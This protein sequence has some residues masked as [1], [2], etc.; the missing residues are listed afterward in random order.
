[1]RH[2]TPGAYMYFAQFDG[3]DSRRG[4]KLL[5][6]AARRHGAQCWLWLAA[7]FAIN[8]LCAPAVAAG[9]TNTAPPVTPEQAQE[10]REFLGQL[11][12]QAGVGGRLLMGMSI[13]A[14]GI[15]VR[16]SGMSL[17]QALL[18]TKR[19]LEN[20]NV[21]IDKIFAP[22]TPTGDALFDRYAAA[23]DKRMAG[24]SMFDLS[25]HNPVAAIPDAELSTWE[26][27]FGGDPRYWELRY[28]CAKGSEQAQL[29]GGFTTPSQLLTEAV[30]RGIATSNT[31]LL[32]ACCSDTGSWNL[33]PDM[34]QSSEQ[35]GAPASDPD[36]AQ[37]QL[38]EQAQLAV[39]NAAVKLDPRQAWGY[40]ERAMYWFGLGDQARG[41]ADLQ[42]GNAAP[43]EADPCP[44][45][46]AEIANA[47]AETS[48]PWSAAVC[49][50]IWDIGWLHLNS[51]P[52]VL[53][54]RD[55]IRESLVCANLS[56]D[57]SSFETWH[58]Y[59]C[60]IA[61]SADNNVQDSVVKIGTAKY[62]EAALL[63]YIEDSAGIALTDAQ[64]ET[65]EHVRGACF[66]I[67]L[68]P[69]FPSASLWA[70]GIL[71][72]LDPPQ[73][74]YTA[75]YLGLCEEQHYANAAPAVFA[76][77]SQVHYPELA[78][79]E[80]MK[81]YEALSAEEQQRRAEERRKQYEEQS[82]R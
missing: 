66:G 70:T 67:S 59:A 36:I 22:P 9:D 7:F 55:H 25:I 1:M 48:P 2:L 42:E 82:K 68:Q 78:L 58:Q 33:P 30:Q 53:R 76:D 29:S 12:S 31:L 4:R 54:S 69:V 77:L 51:S 81:K 10:A 72:V 35:I 18:D 74:Y 47:P 19:T 17:E 15:S 3:T 45:P 62:I 49:G 64:R 27:E 44:W 13:V 23:V 63:D 73:G 50:A 41:L 26:P 71:A 52:F 79:P 75:R 38:E 16:N 43:V 34:L 20:S 5:T 60:H 24:S 46:L 28:F 56:G 80:C 37:M 11:A 32:L 6:L 61:L 65:L 8:A 21:P 14:E 39:L 57:S 40:Y